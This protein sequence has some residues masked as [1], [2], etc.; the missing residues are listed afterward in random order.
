[1]SACVCVLIPARSCGFLTVA[2]LPFRL[3]CQGIDLLAGVLLFVM[4]EVDAFAALLRLCDMYPLHFSA[5]GSGAQTLVSLTDQ[6]LELC[7]PEL[8]SHMLKVRF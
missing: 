7:D 8:R 3:H 1:M 5:A 6:L 4:P 2:V